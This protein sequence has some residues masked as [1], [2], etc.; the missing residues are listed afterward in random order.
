[1]A[2][3]GMTVDLSEFRAATDRAYR[4]GEV[5]RRDIAKVFRDANSQ[6]I[7]TAK[8][9]VKRSKRGSYSLQ[10]PSRTHTA[11]ALRRGV[12]FKVSKKYNLVYYVLSTAW[13]SAIYATGHGS[14]KGNK[15]IESAWQTSQNPVTESIKNGLSRLTENTWK[16]G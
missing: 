5:R 9:L 3:D 12:K 4:M 2:G 6:T 14:W 1:M 16:N 11:G 15:F 13:Y 7:K 8:T 10:Y